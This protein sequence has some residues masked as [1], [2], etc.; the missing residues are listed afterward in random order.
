MTACAFH[1][2]LDKVDL[3]TC[4]KCIQNFVTCLSSSKIQHSNCKT[5]LN[6]IYKS[7][8]STCSPRP[9]QKSICYI[10]GEK[11]L[12]ERCR[13]WLQLS[14]MITQLPK[15]TKKV[16]NIKYTKTALCTRQHIHFIEIQWKVHAV[17]FLGAN[18]LCNTNFS[19]ILNHMLSPA[20]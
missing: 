16:H 18:W 20:K 1:S 6:Q 8:S 9:N 17:T 19:E 7:I 5:T 14:H 13:L 11:Y 15:E 4:R 12:P 3:L 2:R 10:F